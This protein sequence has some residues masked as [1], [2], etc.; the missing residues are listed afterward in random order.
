MSEF[1]V[2]FPPDVEA[3][4]HRNRAALQDWFAGQALSG[5]LS[6]R[7]SAE[8][9]REGETAGEMV[10]RLSYAYADAMLAQREKDGES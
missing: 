5:I 3:S 4:I 2:T 6:R 9:R 7:F 1:N 10:S 8:Y